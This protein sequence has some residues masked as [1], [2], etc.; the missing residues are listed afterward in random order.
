MINKTEW[1]VDPGTLLNY[2]G[3]IDVQVVNHQN[4]GVIKVTVEDYNPEEG[5]PLDKQEILS[6]LQD[7]RLNARSEALAYIIENLPKPYEST[8]FS[9]LWDALDVLEQCGST[10]TEAA[11]E[12]IKRLQDIAN[13]PKARV[14]FSSLVESPSNTRDILIETTDGVVVVGCYSS[15]CFKHNGLA[16]VGVK[17]WAEIPK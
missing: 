8:A 6:K 3:V 5:K 14:W 17:R 13:A 7:R 16:I 2:A 11:L 12:E 10:K 1:V 4:E 9:Q 15:G